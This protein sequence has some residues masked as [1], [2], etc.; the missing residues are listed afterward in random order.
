M[1]ARVVEA[2]LLGAVFVPPLA[3]HRAACLALWRSYYF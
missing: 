2:L 3:G 1:L